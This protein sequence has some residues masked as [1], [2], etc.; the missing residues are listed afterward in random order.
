MLSDGRFEKRKGDSNLEKEDHI[1]QNLNYGQEIVRW[2]EEKKS[3]KSALKNY[4]K[5]WRGSFVFPR[6]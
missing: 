5:C 3:W 2:R 4:V 1:L 6:H